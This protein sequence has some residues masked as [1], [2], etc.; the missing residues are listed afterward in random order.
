MCDL[1]NTHTPRWH[2][3]LPV[4]INT[5]HIQDAQKKAIK[6]R[7]CDHKKAAWFKE[8][9]SYCL[10]CQEG[11]STKNLFHLF[12]CACVCVCHVCLCGKLLIYA[13]THKLAAQHF[14]QTSAAAVIVTQSVLQRK[15]MANCQ[16]E[17][18]R[19]YPSKTGFVLPKH[20]QIKL[21]LLKAD[22]SV[23]KNESRTDSDRKRGGILLETYG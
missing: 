11:Y 20:W 9:S 22:G 17:R 4:Y 18:H 12:R 15:E 3:I 16:Y 19:K 2:C 1:R 8:M 13:V 5:D 10:V 23:W 14:A 7:A 21:G 6:L